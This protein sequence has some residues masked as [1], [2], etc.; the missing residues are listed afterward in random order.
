M[1]E[2]NR[3]VFGQPEVTADPKTFRIKHA[4]DT[5]SYATIDALN[6]QHQIKPLG[7]PTPRGGGNGGEPTLTLAQ[8]LGG[9]QWVNEITARKQ[10]VFH[11]GGDCGSTKGPKTQNLVTDK[12][13]GDFQEQDPKEVPEFNFLLGDIVYSFGEAQ[14]YYDQFYEPYRDYPAPILAVAGNHDGMVTNPI[15]EDVAR[16]SLEAFLNNF[17][18]QSF[19][20]TPEAGGLS[21]T[22][23]IQPGV[24]YTFEAPFVRIIALYSNM[25]EDPGVIADN[26]KVGPE[27]LAFLTTALKRAKKDAA[28]GKLGALIFALHHPPYTAPLA[29]GK[30]GG[31][32]DMLADMDK[33]C[34]EADFWPHA[35]LAG[36]VHNYQRFTRTRPNG[37][38]IPYISCGNMGHNVQRLGSSGTPAMRVPTVIEAGGGNADHV[39]FENY[40]DHNYGY[41]RVVVTDKQLRVEYHAVDDGHNAKAPDDAVTVDLK[42]RKLTHFAANDHGIPAEAKRVRALAKKPSSTPKASKQRLT[43]TAKSKAKG[44]TATRK[45]GKRKKKTG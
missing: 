13:A 16:R 30:H 28:A 43:T 45:A 4:S 27:Q 37:S 19:V 40:D 32:P 9:E 23:Q 44:T 24:Y 2:T 31:S 22:A 35:V 36:H 10:I 15:N 34:A 33:A 11:A 8:V 20:V 26:G 21:R 1:R 38:E 42:T 5:A 25:L 41:L 14:Y 7:F 18:Q 17:C 3:P 12:L 29:G 39:V 6:A